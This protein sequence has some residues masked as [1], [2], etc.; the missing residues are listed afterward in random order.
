MKKRSYYVIKGNN[1][2]IT[3][4]IFDLNIFKTTYSS[5][6]AIEIRQ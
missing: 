2:Q 6:N 3:S 1:K 4:I 5:K